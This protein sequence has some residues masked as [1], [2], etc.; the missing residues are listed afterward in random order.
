MR[1]MHKPKGSTLAQ[2]DESSGHLPF[3][4]S[5]TTCSQNGDAAKRHCLRLNL[6]WS[7]LQWSK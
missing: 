5:R 3:N 4:P 1:N 6:S 2:F 7:S